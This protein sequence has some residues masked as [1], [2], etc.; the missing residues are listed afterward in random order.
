MCRF[1]IKPYA[2]FETSRKLQQS[3]GSYLQLFAVLW[4]V[5]GGDETRENVSST[6]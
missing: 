3:S 1:S 2:K 5:T 6:C 4:K